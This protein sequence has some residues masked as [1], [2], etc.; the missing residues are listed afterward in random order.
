M[1]TSAHN[2]QIESGKAEIKKIQGL[3]EGARKDLTAIAKKDPV[4]RFKTT[5]AKAEATDL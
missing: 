5:L 4:E 3:K 2:A 1:D